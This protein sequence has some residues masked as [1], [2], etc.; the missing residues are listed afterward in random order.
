MLMQPIILQPKK[1][2]LSFHTVSTHLTP[3]GYSA[4]HIHTV[5][6]H[7]SF[8]AS[9]RQWR[10]YATDFHQF[11]LLLSPQIAVFQPSTASISFD[12]YVVVCVSFQQPRSSVSGSPRREDAW[13]SVLRPLLLTRQSSGH[14]MQTARLTIANLRLSDMSPFAFHKISLYLWS[15][16]SSSRKKGVFNDPPESNSI[17]ARVRYLAKQRNPIE[18]TA[19]GSSAFSQVAFTRANVHTIMTGIDV[20]KWTRI[21]SFL[22]EYAFA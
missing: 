14:L 3:G 16:S 11:P 7:A 22:Q 12:F 2:C 20:V 5:A 19:V 17:M 18:S 9:R 4:S 8:M 13:T 21:L 15:Y 10:A 1:H 6:M